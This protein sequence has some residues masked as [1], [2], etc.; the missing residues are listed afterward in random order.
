MVGGTHY[1]LLP[2]PPKEMK[3]MFLGYGLP[4]LKGVM[5][6]ATPLFSK[7]L[8]FAG[9]GESNLEHALI[10]LIREQGDPTIAPYAKEGEV[11]IRLTTRAAS[12]EEALRRMAE[13]EKEIRS[14]VGEFLYAEEDVTIEQVIYRL[15]RD[16]HATL[17]AAESCTGGL[18]ADLLTTVPGSSSVFRGGVVSYSNELKQ[19]FLDVPHTLLEGEGAPGAISP[20]TAKAMAE[21]LLR[22][23]GTDYAVAVTGVAGP[24][25][26]EGKPVGLVYFGIARKGQDTDVLKSQFS[27]NRETIKLKAAKAALYHLWKRLI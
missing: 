25:P 13:T 10:D 26:S 15:L 11:T 4:W 17:S 16:K 2:G 7:M 21:G 23:T 5:S 22:R 18:L 8:K 27:G 9:I 14:R 6:D 20:E 1:M 19:A 3:P 12:E 24:D